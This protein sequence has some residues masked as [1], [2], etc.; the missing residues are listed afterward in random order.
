MIRR[1]PR[2]TLF[3][4]TTLFRSRQLRPGRLRAEASARNYSRLDR[5]SH[6]ARAPARGRARG[7]LARRVHERREDEGG[8]RRAGGGVPRG[9]ARGE[10]PPPP[11][12]PGPAPP[13]PRPSPPPPE[14]PA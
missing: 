7:R 3:P 5:R 9:P 6:A 4:Y 1:P 13:A 2:S 10:V 11:R 14:P 8:A 12:A